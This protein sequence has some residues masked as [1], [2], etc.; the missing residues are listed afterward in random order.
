M[1]KIISYWKV[2]GASTVHALLTQYFTGNSLAV[3]KLV[4]ESVLV[5][6]VRMYIAAGIPK[7]AIES[8]SEYILAP[9]VAE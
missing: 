1:P 9:G 2:S 4:D 8:H 7:V 5:E 6:Y 3:R